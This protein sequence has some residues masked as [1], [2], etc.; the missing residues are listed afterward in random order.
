MCDQAATDRAE[1]VFAGRLLR[2]LRRFTPSG[3]REVVEHPGA[4]AILV[5]DEEGRVLLVRQF[6]EGAGRDLWEIPAGTLK[7]HEKPYACA[8]RELQEE[9][10]LSGK[11]R[12]L[13]LIYPTPGY[14]TERIFLFRCEVK[15]VLPRAQ[16]EIAEARFFSVREIL[17]MALR[18]QG[19]AKTLAALCYLLAES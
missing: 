18:G 13:G 15:G 11:L 3:V 17:D 19:D 10:N 8:K 5:T 14:S 9:V 4:V 16:N 7:P 2:V 6:R 12:F 1:I